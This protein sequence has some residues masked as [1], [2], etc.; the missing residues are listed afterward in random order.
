M[1]HVYQIDSLALSP[2][3]RWSRIKMKA[4]QPLGL[5]P[6]CSLDCVLKREWSL[7]LGKL[8][9][10][11]LKFFQSIISLI[12]FFEFAM[13]SRELNSFLFLNL[14]N[15]LCWR[16]RWNVRLNW[17]R[18]VYDFLCGFISLIIFLRRRFLIFLF[19]IFRIFFFLFFIFH[20][21]RFWF[22]RVFTFLFDYF[23]V[24]F[25]QY[26]IQIFFIFFFLLF[27]LFLFY[28][29]FLQL[30]VLFALFSNLVRTF[31]FIILFLFWGSLNIC[32]RRSLFWGSIFRLGF[33]YFLFNLF[34]FFLGNFILTILGWF[35]Q[36]IVYLIG[37]HHIKIML[38]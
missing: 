15:F 25:F 23:F 2:R 19:R 34:F 29:F 18:F 17:F 13:A 24:T 35:F 8:R 5:P 10:F 37:F 32:I 9:K 12:K 30:L 28:P 7:L 16:R 3:R 14:A 27:F 26:L 4:F 21:N 22:F 6:N 33:N 11:R 36:K 20:P 38:A 1:V 31:F